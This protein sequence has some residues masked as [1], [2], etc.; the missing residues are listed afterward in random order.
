MDG[1]AKWLLL[2][3]YE[4]EPAAFGVPPYI[5]FH[6]R[7]VAGV[8][9]SHNIPYEYVT[10]DE[11]RR[12]SLKSD[13]PSEILNRIGI[14]NLL[15][16]VLIAGAIVPGKYL[17]G[18]PISH[19]EVREIISTHPRSVPF[20]AGGW[21]IR[22]W[23]QQ[24]WNPIKQNLFLTVQDTDATLNNFLDTNNWK[25]QRRTAEQWEKWAIAGAASKAVTNNQDLHG[26]LTY[27]VEVYQGCVRFRNGCKFCIEPK[28]GIPKDRPVDSILA[29]VNAALDSGV[30]HF[31]LGGMTDVYTYMAEG[32][33]DLEYPIPN[34]E[35]ISKL[36][37]GMREDERLDI[38][39]T[40]NANPSIIA[41]NVEP[42]TEI[43]K[44]LCDTLSD[45]S[46]L[47]FGLESAD[48]IVHKE[49]WLN[50]STEQLKVAI[51]H[52][53]QYGR[54]RGN[55]GLPKLLPGLNFIAGLN[56]ESS[57]SYNLN[58]KLLGELKKEG[59]WLR[60][61]NIRQVEGEG[62]QTVD[63]EDFTNFKTWVRDEIDAPLLQELFPIGEQL[64]RVTWESHET[65]FRLP[66][67]LE[68]ELQDPSIHGK[69][70]ITFGRQIGAYP[71][72]VGVPYLIP[73]E[74]ESDIIVTGHGK[75][76]IS[77]VESNLD[78][79]TCTQ[80]QLQA[81]PGI[82]EKTAWKIIS[83]RARLLSK[84]KGEDPFQNP[85]QALLISDINSK[86]HENILRF[87]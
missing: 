69:S 34:P 16:T 6:V 79:N 45:G 65:R 77:A 25:H 70:G 36:L 21:A 2:D 39:H 43:T 35:P 42:A 1:E 86:D 84:N 30:T 87:F 32:V 20:L 5:G 41:E 85:T 82:G 76:S 14:N 9:E 64:K 40:D 28:K 52:I 31:R 59:M 27:E 61:I 62:F 22:G 23:R 12:Y 81:I 83:K 46:V 26:P 37:Y 47:S 74:S 60:R 51:R 50:C 54:T 53:N 19:K 17:R 80:K 7:Y 18:T 55:R 72:L 24:G 57:E 4:D 66:R 56:G 44:L 29:E 73:L 67:H 71:I 49:N 10:I 3:G 78:I 11:W 15:G 68:P 63:E 33:N 38:L 58:K 48:P 8:L 75:R 13:S